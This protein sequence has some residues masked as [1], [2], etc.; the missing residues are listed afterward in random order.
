MRLLGGNTEQEER[1]HVLDHEKLDVYRVARELSREVCRLTKKARRKRECRDMID[2]V[3]RATASIPLNLAEGS[4]ETS[5][6]RKRISTGLPGVRRRNYPLRS[7][8]WW[9]WRC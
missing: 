2:Q 1:M 7:T 8:I 9:T 5:D 3:N 4:G 6:G